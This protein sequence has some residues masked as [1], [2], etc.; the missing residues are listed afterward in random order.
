MLR[1]FKL[2]LFTLIFSTFPITAQAKPVDVTG[3]YYADDYGTVCPPCDRIDETSG[4][5]VVYAKPG[6]HIYLG[7]AGKYGCGTAGTCSAF[8][9]GPTGF[10][11]WARITG[12]QNSEVFQF[13][14]AYPGGTHTIELRTHIPRDYLNRHGKDPVRYNSEF[15]YSQA[16]MTSAVFIIKPDPNKCEHS[17]NTWRYDANNHWKIC[18]TC[19]TQFAVGGHTLNGSGVCTTCGGKFHTHSYD[20][21]VGTVKPPTCTQQGVGN[22]GCNCG[23]G[24]T[25]QKPIPVNPNN[26]TFGAPYVTKEPTCTTTGQKH[27]KCTGCGHVAVDS[28]IPALGHDFQWKWYP[29]NG[30]E[31]A[32]KQLTCTRCGLTQGNAN[33]TTYTVTYQT[34]DKDNNVVMQTKTATKNRGDIVNGND[35]GQEDITYQG[36]PYAY[37]S[38]DKGVYVNGETVVKR[39]YRKTQYVI[40]Y[41]ANGGTGQMGTQ[42]IKYDQEATLLPNQF[43]KTGYDFKGWS[44]N[45]T[46]TP[47]YSDG[48]SVTNVINRTEGGNTITLYAIWEG[49]KYRV[50]FQDTNWHQLEDKIVT[51]DQP[52]GELP[53]P[54]DENYRLR[55]W[56]YRIYN[57][58]TDITEV[59]I[60]STTIVTI[61]NDHELWGKWKEKAWDVQ[62][63]SPS[64][65]Q[66]VTVLHRRQVQEPF[67]PNE[68][69][70]NFLY[71]SETPNGKTPFD[72]S[73]PIVEDKKLYAVFE[74]ATYTITLEGTGHVDRIYPCEIG[75]LP[76]GVQTGKTFD[77]WYYDAALTQK[78]NSTDQ[79]PPRDITVYPKFTTGEYKLTLK[80]R[81]ES[82]TLKYGQEIPELPTPTEEG[83]E[84]KGWMYQ[85]IFYKGGDMFEWDHNVELEPVWEIKHITV[86]YPDGTAK[87]KDYG[88]TVGNLPTP[89]TVTGKDFIGYKDQNGDWVTESTI[90]KKDTII[91]YVYE[92]ASITLT[93]KDG[94][95]EQL[96]NVE[97]GTTVIDLP[98]RSKD[99]Y[100][101]KGWSTSPNGAVTRGPFYF[102]TTL[103]AV[104]AEGEQDVVFTDL[105]L[106]VKRKTGQQLGTL[107]TFSKEGFRF[108]GWEHNG[109][110]VGPTT[111]TPVGGLVLNARLEAINTGATDIVVIRYWSDGV[112]INTEDLPIGEIL[113]D[114]GAPPMTSADART[115]QY[116]SDQPNGQRYDF[117]HMVN[118]DVDLYAVWK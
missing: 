97:S 82:W 91:E 1:K 37:I 101:F 104:Y 117:G 44:K 65:S 5:V 77:G 26:H 102:D 64:K 47:M 33:W 73:T 70:M 6:T 43:K 42:T 54:T 84:F 93:L 107:P 13:L 88:D 67:T 17:S 46:G 20:K 87:P 50:K 112:R 61:P 56:V 69:G 21:L 41:D 115:F 109:V 81:T 18:D 116:W 76:N 14:Y 90:V 58:A 53:Y 4:T 103:Y 92:A 57:T 48:Q 113:W 10:Y 99:G 15:L 49:A 22:F 40:T 95:W 55:Q 12:Y 11:T 74:A 32:Y 63:L 75:N 86:Y 89:P 16:R 27:K 62:F 35:I 8:I 78:V 24:G 98:Q 52:Y 108:L 66:V 85:S 106:T 105:N 96:K 9:D 72:F 2:L 30:V 110:V 83:K 45:K 94:D 38:C 39:Y 114:P 118:A 51:F 23:Q 59:P 71:W 25:V 34:V 111:V 31:N 7:L 36:V 19:G 68:V 79:M 100:S 3:T 28:T 60:D 29:N 80:G